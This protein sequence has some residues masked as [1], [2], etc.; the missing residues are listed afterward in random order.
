MD[1]IPKVIGKRSGV[2]VFQY[3]A[4]ACQWSAKLFTDPL[5]HQQNPPTKHL[6]IRETKRLSTHSLYGGEDKLLIKESKNSKGV[7]KDFT[8]GISR[9]LDLPC[10]FCTFFFTQDP[11]IFQTALSTMSGIF[12]IM[13]FSVNLWTSSLLFNF[14]ERTRNP[15]KFFYT[16]GPP[17]IR[18]R[19]DFMFGQHQKSL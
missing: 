15:R 8:F 18:P 9:F 13:D 10:Y 2:G 7:G 4:R 5:G 14:W 11:W 1:E 3:P 6:V 12:T 17:V 16:F 19:K